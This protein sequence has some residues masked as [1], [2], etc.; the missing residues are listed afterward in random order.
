MS[1]G[2][3]VRR[4]AVIDRRYFLTGAASALLGA[5]T[6]IPATGP[7]AYAPGEGTG[8]LVPATD[9]PFKVPPVNLSTIP[10][11]FHRQIVRDSTGEAPGTIVVDP[12]RKYLYL[13]LDNGRARR[14]GI[15]VGREGF[16]WNGS[17]TIGMKRK[18]PKWYPPVEM[19][20][21]DERARQFA[22]GMEGGTDNSLGARAMYLFQDGRDT[23]YRIHGTNE[24][25][26]IG[27][28]VSSGCIRMLNADVIDLYDRVQVGTKVIVLAAANPIAQLGHAITDP[29]SDWRQGVRRL[30]GNPI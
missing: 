1:R 8:V 14:Y 28:A 22:S 30:A 9:E 26:S 25:R 4:V 16:G 10:S 6:A 18:W 7:L 29:D 12:G 17:A 13:V 24:P 27:Q 19:Q 3:H 23:L 15:G 5:C 21:R 2:A 11:Q 20:A